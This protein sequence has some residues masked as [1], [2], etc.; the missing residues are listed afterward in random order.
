MLQGVRNHLSTLLGRRTSF[1]APAFR[2]DGPQPRSLRERLGAWHADAEE[3][4]GRLFLG[5]QPLL[6]SRKERDLFDSLSACGLLERVGP[7]VYR[8]C[9]RLFPLYGHFIATDA[10]TH[11]DPDQVFSLMFEQVYLVR[12]MDVQPEDAVLE[13][14]L[15]S[16]VNSIFAADRASSV[17]GV[18]INPRALEFA[19]FN[20]ALNGCETP[21]DL[22]EGSLFEPVRGSLYDLILVNPPF[23]LVPQEETWFLHSDGGEDGLD[24]IR[25]ILREAPAHLAPDG[26][27]E[28]I[29]WSPGSAQ[30]PLLVD[31]M[32]EAFPRHRQHVHILDVGPIDAHL[33]PFKEC[34]GYEAWRERLA[35]QGLSDVYFLFVRSEPAATPGV[36]ITHPEAEVAACDTIS[37]PWA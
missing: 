31:L 19:R 20:Q 30:G 18:D 7:S 4:Y 9:V 13:L 29:T 34:A 32:R 16:G 17:T 2:S 36:E 21:V 26:R 5:G 24:V 33:G 3:R 6:A 11:R 25:T 15:G 12:N 14:C 8:P 22:V 23:E 28:I 37:D 35:Q 27:F 10:L 1:P